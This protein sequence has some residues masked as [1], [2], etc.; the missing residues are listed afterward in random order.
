MSM[1]FL[2]FF[3]CILWGFNLLCRLWFDFV[4]ETFV[5]EVC[6]SSTIDEE[7]SFGECCNFFAR[8]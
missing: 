3:F 2:F 8:V 4:V 5:I 6:S 7:L 1:H